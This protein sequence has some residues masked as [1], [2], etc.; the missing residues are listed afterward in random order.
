MAEPEAAIGAEPAMDEDL[1]PIDAH[2]GTVMQDEVFTRPWVELKR[3]HPRSFF[4]IDGRQEHYVATGEFVC[5]R[6]PVYFRAK[7]GPHCD[8]ET[9]QSTVARVLTVESHSEGEVDQVWL[10]LLIGAE[11]FSAFPLAPVMPPSQQT[12]IQFPPEIIWTN[13]A[14]LLEASEVISEAFV[15]RLR[16]ILFNDAGMCY[17]MENAFFVRLR[18]DRDTFE[19]SGIADVSGSGFE[20]FP[21]TDC[22]T[23]RQWENLLRIARLISFEMARSSIAQST[24]QSK[25]V[26]C[27]KTMWDYLLYRLQPQVEVK[28]KIGVS[29]ILYLRKN[30]TK[31]VIKCRVVK[32]TLRLDTSS[33]FALL[34]RV[35][36]RSITLGLRNPSPRAPKL[37]GQQSLSHIA[38]HSSKEDSFNLFF[39]LPENSLDGLTHRPRHRGVDFHFD[40]NRRELRVAFR[41]RRASPYDTTVTE[42]LASQSRANDLEESSSA[43]TEVVDDGGEPEIAIKVGDHVGND[44]YVCSVKRVLNG[45]THVCVDVLESTD[46]NFVAGAERILT[47]EHAIALYRQYNDL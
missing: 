24:R 33:L 29:T 15:F 21:F 14:V 5:L 35:L 12:Y 10:N 25:K 31:E 8:A 42:Y 47:M 4:E 7:R 18:W 1:Y 34:Q 17:G 45:S 40:S 11:D 27:T 20:P 44:H 22:Y 16:H 41:F 28:E 3:K 36:G 6:R 13:A 9:L 23:R 30:G 37:R 38:L 32:E 43:G 2:E 46:I 26:H 19:W 39:P